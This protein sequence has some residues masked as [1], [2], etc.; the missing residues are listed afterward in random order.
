[1]PCTTKRKRR[2]MEHKMV[3]SGQYMP[4]IVHPHLL[5]GGGGIRPPPGGEGGGKHTATHPPGRLPPTSTHHCSSWRAGR[6]SSRAK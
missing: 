4:H 3:A 2:C 1:M 5:L 6:G